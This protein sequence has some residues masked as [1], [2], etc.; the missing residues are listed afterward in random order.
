MPVRFALRS[1]SFA[2]YS[3]GQLCQSGV[4]DVAGALP[5]GAYV[6][7]ITGHDKRMVSI[8]A[9][10]VAGEETLVTAVLGER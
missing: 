2:G 7:E 1:P 8:P 4:T 10:L 6:V 9:V 3:T 5:P